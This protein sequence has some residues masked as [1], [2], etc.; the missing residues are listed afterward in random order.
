MKQAGIG[1]IIFLL[2]L[3]ACLAGKGGE[4]M[5]DSVDAHPSPLEPEVEAEIMEDDNMKRE[6]C[7]IVTLEND[8]FIIKN[9]AG[10]LYHIDNSFLGEFTQ[11]SEVLLLYTERNQIA[12]NTY[13]ATVKAVFPHNSVLQYPA[14]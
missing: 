8:F 9:V 1:I 6:F 3:L 11:G 10:E 14:N 7:T 5:L 13:L 2:G 12:D 4:G